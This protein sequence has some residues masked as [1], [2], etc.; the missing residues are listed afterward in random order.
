[1]RISVQYF[2]YRT[3]RYICIPFRLILGV[4]VVYIIYIMLR[5]R[6]PIAEFKMRKS[7]Y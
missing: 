3:L 5:C 7:R 6:V 1:M 4:E 2:L